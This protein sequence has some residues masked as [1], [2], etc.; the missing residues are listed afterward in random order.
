MKEELIREMKA[1]FGNDSKRVDHALKVLKHAEKINEFVKA[2]KKI[3][4][5][6]AILHDIGILEAERKH[7]SSAG[8]YQEMEGPAIAAGILL[9]FDFNTDELEHISRIIANHHSN[10]NIDTDE[11]K[12][13]WDA[14]W[15]VNIPDDYKD[16]EKDK[17][18][19]LSETIFKTVKGRQLAY[20]KFEE[21][22]Q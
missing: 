16:M 20:E 21:F 10:K 3:V 15:L 1:V 5:A 2:D 18:K 6:A 19:N 9:R 17:L 11:F 13:I 14:D 4:T 22:I 8:I 12:V 7:G